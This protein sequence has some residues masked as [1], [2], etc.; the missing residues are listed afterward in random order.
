[1][2]VLVEGLVVWVE[3][4]STRGYGLEPIEWDGITLVYD[5]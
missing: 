5:G 2:A 4:R 3:R 1:M